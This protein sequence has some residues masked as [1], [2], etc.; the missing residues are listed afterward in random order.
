MKI[1]VLGTGMVGNAIATKL[2]Q[3]GQ[4]VMMGSRSV[5][6]EAGQEWLRSVDGK[7]QLG[8]FA[9]AQPSA[10]FCS[11]VPTARIHLPHCGKPVR[12]TCAVKFSFK[13]EIRWTLRRGCRR[14]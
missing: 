2:V 1:A 10:K 12:P 3:L 7:A 6:K 5:S 11:I 14:H 9:D 13:S 8:T 4:A